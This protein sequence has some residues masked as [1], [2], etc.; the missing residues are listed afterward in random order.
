MERRIDERME[1]C[2]V[3]SSIQNPKRGGMGSFSYS[4]GICKTDEAEVEVSIHWIF[5]QY[6]DKLQ[7]DMKKEENAISVLKLAVSSIPE[8]VLDNFSDIS[9][10]N[11][12]S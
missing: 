11:P 8:D 3:S 12:L 9:C 4:S 10:S 5:E 7:N 2:I 6:K 1:S